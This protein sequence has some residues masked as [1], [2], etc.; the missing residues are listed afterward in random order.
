[1]LKA[2][3]LVQEDAEETGGFQALLCGLF[4]PR[5]AVK[6]LHCDLR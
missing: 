3:K 4:K 5:D 6:Y 1:V 2:A